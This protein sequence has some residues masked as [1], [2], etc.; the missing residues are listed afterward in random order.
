MSSEKPE[1]RT[2]I[3]ETTWRLLEEQSAAAV[4]MKDIAKAVGISRQALYLHFAS[5]AE[6][7]VA[8]T[9]YMEE[10]LG[11][12]A[13]IARWR[14]A[15][16]GIE[17]LESYVEFWG[18]YLPEVYGVA[19]ALIA[20]YASDAAA[21]EAW[22]GRL[23]EIR[24]GC[25]ISIAALARDGLLAPAWSPATATDLFATLLSVEQWEK[26]TRRCGWST[27]EYISRTQTLVR[28]AFVQDTNSSA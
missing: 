10:A 26:L 19:K 5:R 25:Q 14:T 2:R 24:S 3:L 17:L 28:R 18:N 8:T 16:N 21:A 12:D 27:P 20:V 4:H 23:A 15:T 22:D 11:L 13:R 1:T 7:L 9:I 6:L